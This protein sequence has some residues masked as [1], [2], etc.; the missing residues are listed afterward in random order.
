M[1]TSFACPA[2]HAPLIQDGDE[3]RTQDSSVRYPQVGGI[4]WLF[5]DPRFTLADWKERASFQITYL[6]NEIETLK[7]AIKSSTSKL[8]R[9]R[10]EAKRGLQIQHIE[11]LRKV[12]APLKPSSKLSLPQQKAFGYRLPLRQGLMGYFPNLIRDWNVDYQTEN[13]ALLNAVTTLLQKHESMTSHTKILVLGAGASRLAYDL[14]LLPASPQVMAFDLNPILLLAAKSI[15]SGQKIQAVESPF[16]PKNPMTPGRVVE[17]MAPAGATSRLSFAFGDVYALPFAES[18]FDICITPWLI[19][20]LPRHL[21]ELT[22]SIARVLKPQGVWLNSG[23]WHFE[24][25][26][27]LENVSLAE[28]CERAPEF[29]FKS[30]EFGQIETP[31]LQSEFDAHRRF[32]TLSQ[33]AWR[34]D[35]TPPPQ[36]LPAIDDRAPWIIQPTQPVPALPTLMQDAQTHAVK[37]LVLSLVDGARSLHDIA[38][39]VAEENSLSADQ[40]L[41]AVQ[42]FF[43]R[44][45]SDHRFRGES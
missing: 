6:E 24:F 9:Q 19:D 43:D 4:P 11:M 21:K 45:L 14:S 34:R 41:D 32:E 30:L 44:Y 38:A 27:E 33:F 3:W 5:P 1:K 10:L 16:S 37:A 2:T 18:S 35:H 42:T 29:G 8:T 26:N 31:Y 15:S 17:L 25:R 40:A 7:A 20:I 12:L 39:I 36:T 22:A 23:S 28:A 13:Q